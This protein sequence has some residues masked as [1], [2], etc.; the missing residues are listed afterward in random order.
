M[1]GSQVYKSPLAAKEMT[2]TDLGCDS[3]GDEEAE[4][5]AFNDVLARERTKRLD[6][7]SLAQRVW[8]VPA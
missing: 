7:I 4:N 1:S 5:E 6:S 3:L 2:G 8:G